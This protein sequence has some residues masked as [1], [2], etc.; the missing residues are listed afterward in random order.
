MGQSPD[1]SER[2]LL[3]PRLLGLAEAKHALK[4]AEMQDDK[5]LSASEHEPTTVMNRANS[6]RSVVLATL[7]LI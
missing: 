6:M 4:H 5:G 7:R 2:L 1:K 3:R